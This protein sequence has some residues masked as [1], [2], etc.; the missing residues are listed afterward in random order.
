[1]TGQE[2]HIH[3][4]RYA[5]SLLDTSSSQAGHMITIGIIVSTDA[6]LMALHGHSSKH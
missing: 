5:N 2:G 3:H 1:M 6:S 4:T